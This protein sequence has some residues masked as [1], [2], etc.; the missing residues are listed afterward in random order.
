MVPLF[1]TA[2]EGKCPGI[3]LKTRT[4]D[5]IKPDQNGFDPAF[6]I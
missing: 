2:V 1:F 3:H 4:I 6:S 5:I